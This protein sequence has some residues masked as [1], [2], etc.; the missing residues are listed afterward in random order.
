MFI[1]TVV[2]YFFYQH[3]NT[4]IRCRAIAQFANVHTRPQTDM[5]TPVKTPNTF[6]CVVKNLFCI[7][8]NILSQKSKVKSQKVAKLFFLIYKPSDQLTYR[9]LCHLTY[10]SC[11]LFIYRFNFINA[12]RFA[13][14]Q[15]NSTA[16]T[17]QI[18]HAKITFAK[19]FGN[20]CYKQSTA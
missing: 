4:I 13:F 11:P 15:S 9:P 18:E 8:H 3:V 6:F 5:F 1:N 17:T 14:L 12:V 2:N 10:T 16:V 7:S 20:G 19:V